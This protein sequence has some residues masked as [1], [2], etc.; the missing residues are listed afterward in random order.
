[1]QYFKDKIWL[2]SVLFLFLF[3][4]ERQNSSG[5]LIACFGKGRSTVK[6]QTSK[7]VG[8]LIL[9]I[10]INDFKYILKNIYH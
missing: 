9:N 10:F 6:R 4:K 3:H 5:A 7:E 1:M 8:I 2:A